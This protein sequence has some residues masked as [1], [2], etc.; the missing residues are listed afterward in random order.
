MSFNNS[1]GAE[2]QD[3][4]TSN[5][6]SQTQVD[7]ESGTTAAHQPP[8][9]LAVEYPP[10]PIQQLTVSRSLVTLTQQVAD[11]FTKKLFQYKPKATSKE[12]DGGDGDDGGG[13]DDGS[14]D[15]DDNDDDDDSE[16]SDDASAS[17]N[18]KND[19]MDKKNRDVGDH[20]VKGGDQKKRKRKVSPNKLVTFHPPK[21]VKDAIEEKEDDHDS[22]EDFVLTH[23]V[24]T[25]M[26][27]KERPKRARKT[28]VHKFDDAVSS[29]SSPKKSPSFA[30]KSN[31]N[32]DININRDT[33]NAICRAVLKNR[34]QYLEAYKNGDPKTMVGFF[35]TLDNDPSDS[36]NQHDYYGLQGTI[37]ESMK[38]DTGRTNGDKLIIM[39]AT[40]SN[41]DN[42]VDDHIGTGA[43][44][45][46]SSKHYR[47]L[48]YSVVDAS[49]AVVTD[50][51]SLLGCVQ[52][53]MLPTDLPTWETKI[54]EG[55][56]RGLV[57][58]G[59][60]K[61][62]DW[63]TCETEK[64]ASCLRVA[65]GIKDAKKLTIPKRDTFARESNPR[66]LDGSP[67]MLINMNPPQLDRLANEGQFKNQICGINLKRDNCFCDDHP[68]G[69]GKSLKKNDVIFLK[70]TDVHLVS[71]YVYYVGAYRLTNGVDTKCKVG[72]VKAMYNE[73]EN[74]INR[75]AQVTDV[76]ITSAKKTSWINK[77]GGV[78]KITYIDRGLVHQSHKRNF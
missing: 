70:G 23:I 15:D 28:A 53:E 32:R 69:C 8:Q 72:V 54:V 2:K 25:A 29:V 36:Y 34:E 38:T 22:S 40:K 31:I 6:I 49:K 35:N 11:D 16:D 73:T 44:R 46:S 56:A 48:A 4:S 75:I 61:R 67:Y 58:K 37:I 24:A 3:S 62:N 60:P 1:K 39:K 10:S 12:K 5:S 9:P 71:G 74:V 45:K 21:N 14:G 26:N 51:Y 68:S 63:M 55:A 19:R 47:P 33:R 65:H 78:A 77:V 7:E 18:D 76:C 20:D 50:Q 13:D 43:K 30:M 57:H 42:A 27:K 17:D 41:S 66:S 59:D 64:Q 52:R